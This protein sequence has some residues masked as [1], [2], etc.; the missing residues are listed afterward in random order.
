MSD[1]LRISGWYSGG[2]GP[3]PF[4]GDIYDVIAYTTDLGESSRQLIEQYQ[5]AKWGIALDKLAGAGTEI[6][7]ATAHDAGD[8]TN[9]ATNG[10]NVFTTRYLERLAESADLMLQ[11]STGITLDLKGDT[12]D[13][14]GGAAAG[15]S[16]TLQT[17]NGD[18]TDV[19]SGTIRT[20]KTGSGA[21]LNG[22]I[23]LIAGGAGNINLDT[24]NLE[25]LNGGQVSLTAGGDVSLTQTSALNLGSVSGQNVSIQTTGGTSDV[26]LNNTITASGS[27]NALTVASGRNFINNAGA[28][29]GALNTTDI[30]G[31]WLV[32][33]AD[34][35]ANTLG[36]LAS[37]FKRY[38]KT[39]AGYAPGSVVETGDGLLYSIAPTLSVTAQNASRAYGD[40]NSFTYSISG[41]I[42]GDTQGSATS[43][44]ASI[45]SAA[46]QN[47]NVGS[48]AITSALGT[49]ASSLGYQ[50][51]TFN[52]AT[53]TINK[54]PLS[55]SLAQSNYSRAQGAANPSFTL[56]YSGFKLGETTSV[57]D[58]LPSAGTAAGTSSTSGQ[59]AIN[60]SGGSDNNYSFSY[61]SPAGYLSVETAV[62]PS[63]WEKV[64]YAN[65]GLNLGV[66]SPVPL[67]S[68]TTSSAPAGESNS[69]SA[70]ENEDN[71]ENGKPSVR[72]TQGQNDTET[73]SVPGLNVTIEASLART[74]G[75]TQEK[76]NEMFR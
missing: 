10:Y 15:K 3:Y 54:V 12:L 70:G 58:S 13:L 62:L 43:G 61:P 20:T 30:N 41:F 29:A 47:S 69:S 40:A 21:G 16:I 7:E 32:Y 66:Q 28:G 39:Y 25:A 37:D 34:P 44:A 14:T 8:P 71:E 73:L 33:S 68:A 35:S 64:A 36:G 48:Y 2:G 22:N 74:L 57:L 72:R 42:D 1:N 51:T 55:V 4:D 50:F 38:N 26:T 19:S 76:I 46:T 23:A 27:G 24:T 75:L 18:I 56:N 17:D 6:A 67:V 5:S 45:T 65:D 11:A 52:P 9:A 49:L 53:L 60:I 31:R 59:Y 63:T